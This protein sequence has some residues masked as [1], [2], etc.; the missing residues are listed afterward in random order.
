MST[1]PLETACFEKFSAGNEILVAARVSA[2]Y[3][4][5][6]QTERNPRLSDPDGINRRD[7]LTRSGTTAVVLTGVGAG[8]TACEE[9]PLAR[10]LKFQ[11]LDQALEELGRL[12][13]NPPKLESEWSVAKVLVHCAQSIEYSMQGFPQNR[14]VIIRKLIG[15]MVYARFASKGQMSHDLTDP[16]PGAPDITNETDLGAAYT[17][18]RKAIADFRAFSGETREHFAFGKLNKAEYEVAHAMHLANHFSQMEIG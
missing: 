8:V 10:E 17:R 13:Q 5:T 7:F 12:E 11:T 1:I 2:L 18:L 16:I 3:I 6:M 14:S 4:E 9:I 15:P